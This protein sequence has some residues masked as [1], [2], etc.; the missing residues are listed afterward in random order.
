MLYYTYVSRLFKPGLQFLQALCPPFLGLFLSSMRKALKYFQYVQHLIYSSI[1][2]YL[3]LLP[4]FLGLWRKDIIC[5]V[6]LIISQ[7]IYLFPIWPVRTIVILVLVSL[8]TS[9]SQKQNKH[10]RFYQQPTPVA[11]AENFRQ[12][13]YGF[14][15]IYSIHCGSKSSSFSD[16]GNFLP[17]TIYHLGKAP[18]CQL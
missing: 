11:V 10:K 9:A 18:D 4:R 2:A 16:I 8:K 12:K 17:F 1:C 5:I 14:Y 7:R 15:S 6:D 13:N 3:S